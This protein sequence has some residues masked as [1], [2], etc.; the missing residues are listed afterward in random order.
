MYNFTA[1]IAIVTA[2]AS[3]LGTIAK[4]KKVTVREVLEVADEVVKVLGIEDKVILDL[5]EKRNV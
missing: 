2:V 4:D 3:K 1:I 5:T